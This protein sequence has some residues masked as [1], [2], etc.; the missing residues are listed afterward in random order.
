MLYNT[1]I[2]LRHTQCNLRPHQ[3]APRQLSCKALANSQGEHRLHDKE[4]GSLSVLPNASQQW[5]VP[6]LLMQQ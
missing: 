2:G 6:G 3:P 1:A 4:C 5:R